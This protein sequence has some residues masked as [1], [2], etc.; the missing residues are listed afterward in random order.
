MKAL[1]WKDLLLHR[2]PLI[3]ALAVA[4]APYAFWPMATAMGLDPRHTIG[5]GVVHTAGVAG[6]F[7]ALIVIA[8]LTGGA[9]ATERD[10]RSAEFLEY[11]PC[12]RAARAG[13]K[14]VLIATAA[15]LMWITNPLV[16][17]PLFDPDVLQTDPAGIGR[18]VRGMTVAAFA[19]FGA[20]WLS[21]TRVA[22]AAGLLI[23][24]LAPFSVACVAALLLDPVYNAE[25][26]NA[27]FLWGNVAIGVVGFAAGMAVWL[28]GPPASGRG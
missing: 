4:V 19:T 18:F 15:A 28:L 13:S 9:F 24:L 25:A 8:L 17:F 21:T 22:S 10:D 20:A 3:C 5:A 7:G 16:V 26:F 23:G 1:L 27:A 6:L 14:L 12:T 11:L 2:G